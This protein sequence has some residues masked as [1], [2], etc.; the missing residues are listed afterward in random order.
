MTS[1]HGLRFIACENYE[2][3]SQQAAHLVMEQLRRKPDLLLCVATGGSPRRMYELLAQSYPSEPQL[4]SKLRLLKLDEWGGLARNNAAS[5][6]MYIRQYLLAPLKIT[7][8][9]FF[10]FRGDSSDHE[11]ECERI[12]NLLRQL[13]PPDVTILGIGSNGHLA[14]NEPADALIPHAHTARLTPHSQTHPMLAQLSH[15]PT[16]GITI[17]VADI[18]QSQKILLLI[19]GAHKREALHR[20]HTENISTQFPASLLHLHADALCLHDAEAAGA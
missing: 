13:G 12:R 5:C 2:L 8:D 6:E 10:T 1:S 16:F 14:M 4:F 15:K 20:L 18:L 19:N 3:L 11:A 9:R 7:E 17:G